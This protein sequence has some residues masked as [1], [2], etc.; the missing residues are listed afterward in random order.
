MEQIFL[1]AKEIQM[2]VIG[3]YCSNRQVTDTKISHSILKLA[4]QIDL[5]NL[6]SSTMILFVCYRLTKFNPD[7]MKEESNLGLVLYR[8]VGNGSE[9]DWK[10]MAKV[11]VH[12]QASIRAKAK[13]LVNSRMYENLNDFDNHLINI[14]LDWLSNPGLKL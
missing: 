6:Q 14:N 12:N 13:T 11:S 4:S 9:N 8:N 10:E 1:Y 5:K 3:L 2:E 7:L